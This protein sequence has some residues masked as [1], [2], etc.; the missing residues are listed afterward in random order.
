VL[1]VGNA[2]TNLSKGHHIYLYDYCSSVAKLA[3]YT[4][5]LWAAAT[6]FEQQQIFWHHQAEDHH[7][8]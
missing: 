1:V 6:R 4:T 2:T 7:F 3:A 5:K 8:G